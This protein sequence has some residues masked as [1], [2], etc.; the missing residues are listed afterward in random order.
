MPHDSTSRLNVIRAR[1]EFFRTFAN[2]IE[3]TANGITT[4]VLQ[5]A[6]S[7]L[8][9]MALE[10]NVVTKVTATALRDGTPVKF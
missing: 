3:T 6:Y 9:A 7:I 5:D 10:Q 1:A 4:D 2:V 8:G